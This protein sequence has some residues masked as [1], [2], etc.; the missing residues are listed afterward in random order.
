[1]AGSDD[2]RH[3]SLTG[4]R[5]RRF[6]LTPVFWWYATPAFRTAERAPGALAVDAWSAD[7]THHTMS[8]WE[9]KAAMHAYLADPVHRRAARAFPRIATGKTLGLPADELPSRAAAQDMLAREG[10]VVGR[11]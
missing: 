3:L 8:L 5:V 2:G 6:W 1:M 10:R 11:S 4:L 7:G 9:S